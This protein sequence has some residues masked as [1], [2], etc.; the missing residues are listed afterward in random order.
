MNKTLA[1]NARRALCLVLTLC[2]AVMLGLSAATTAHADDKQKELE[3]KKQQLQDQI[4][5]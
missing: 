3:A 5:D 1:Q 2:M 4:D